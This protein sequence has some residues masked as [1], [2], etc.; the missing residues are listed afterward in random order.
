MT[1]LSLP[2]LS[3]DQK[4][5][6]LAPLMD[7]AWAMLLDSAGDNLDYNRF[8]IFC[9]QPSATISFNGVK[10]DI[11]S[12][13][14]IANLD[15]AEPL[16]CMRQLLTAY[17]SVPAYA[18][19]SD[20]DESDNPLPFTGGWL[21]YISYDFGRHLESLPVIATDDIGLPQ[22][23]MGLY[24]WALITDHKL[25]QT[26]LYNFGLAPDRWSQVCQKIEPVVSRP[27]S[28]NGT[29]E[30]TTPWKSNTSEV[31]Y[32]DKFNRIQQYIHNG[33]CYQVN[34]AQ[35]FTA[36]YAGDVSVAY[37]KLADANKAPFSAY[38][39]FADH[40]ILS[41]SPER[42]IESHQG[43]VLTQPIKGTRPRSQNLERDKAL[44][45]ELIESEKDRAENLMI[46]D[47]LRNDLSR[48][49]A[50]GSVEVT[51]LF[52]HYRF[53][54][55]HHLISTVKSRLAD[56]FDNFDLLATTLPG[57]SI[58]GAP[59]IRAMEII[60]ELEPVRRNLY[61]GII[62]YID[63]NGNMDTNICIR[64]LIAKN[65]RLYCWAGGGL[66][67]DSEVETEYQETFD[68]LAK[69]LPVIAYTSTKP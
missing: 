32:R 52:G 1:S 7:A 65:D 5:L 29:F 4:R 42:F 66:V 53:E 60:E 44:A 63:F 12:H 17:Q 13:I 14:D 26:R 43:E 61:C 21:G 24:Q 56:G 45:N 25:A 57:G 50:K 59:K 54:S 15:Y 69:I 67:A 16:A 11:E 58:T 9:A 38:L 23:Q 33:D 36:Q 8:D 2:Y 10:A 20:S 22:L 6:T 27:S 51:E 46:V 41:V 28:S 3:R 64:T 40:Q 49:A 18:D 35:R 19:K 55:V 39:K 37:Q 30:L 48:T 62:G 34:F 31:E 47:L 68:K